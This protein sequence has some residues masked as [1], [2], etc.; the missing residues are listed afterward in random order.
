MRA[1]W[2]R[3]F[4]EKRAAFAKVLS[5]IMLTMFSDQPGGPVLRAAQVESREMSEGRL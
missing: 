3:K 1:F 4:Q 2:R 5:K